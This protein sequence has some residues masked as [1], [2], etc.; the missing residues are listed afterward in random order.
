MTAM[1]TLRLLAQNLIIIVILAVVLEMLLPG[2]EMRKFTKMV[3]GLMVIV[4]LVQ[5]MNGISGGSLFREIEDYAW[6]SAPAGDRGPDILDQ[7]RRLEAENRRQAVE[8]YKKGMERQIS[9]L[10]GPGEKARLLGAELKIQGDPSRS[11]FGRIQGVS[12]VFGPGE[13]IRTV[14]PVSLG[15]D[16]ESA[17]PAGGRPPPEYSGEALKAARIVANFY[18]LPSDR[19]KVEFRD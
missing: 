14:E 9:A 13:G 18:N 17:R 12:L 16:G 1:E 6:R 19:V 15:P 2:G 4:A 3:L 10:V 11:D 8:Q 7:G 5:A